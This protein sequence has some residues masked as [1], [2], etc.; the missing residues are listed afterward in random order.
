MAGSE[1]ALV[2]VYVGLVLLVAKLFEDIVRRARLPG[3]IGA[4]IAGYILGPGGLNIIHKEHVEAMGLLLVVGIDFLLF[5]AGAEELSRMRGGLRPRELSVATVLMLSTTA[6]TAVVAHLL[7][8][9]HL[10][11]S[12]SL[13]F[14]IVMAIV[15]LGPLTRALIDSGLIATNAGLTVTR[16]GLIAEVG[17][18]LAFN[19]VYAG[20][21]F[22]NAI[23]TPLFFIAVYLFG[24]RLLTRILYLVEDVISAREAPF[25]IIVA[26][27][28]TASYLAEIIGFNAAVTA[29]LLGF[30]ASTYLE[31]R[32][33][34][35]ERL[36]AFTYGF[37]E[38]LFFAGIGLKV[39]QL[40][41]SSMAAM[42]LITLAAA[43]PKLLTASAAG[44][45]P[46][47]IALL[48]KG[49]VDA[50]LL[51]TLYETPHG[52]GNL[53]P[54]QLYT[55]GVFSMLLLSTL[56]ALGLRSIQPP[57][58]KG[59]KEPWRMRIGELGLGYDV[60]RR[61]DNL[62]TVSMFVS[63]SQG[64]AVV[65]IDE[66]GRPIGYITAAD[67]I[68]IAP[69][70]MRRL[71]AEE[72]MRENVP[73]VKVTDRVT[74]LLREHLVAEPIVA[75]VDEDGHL[76]GTLNPHRVLQKIYGISGKREH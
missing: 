46:T 67:L 23:T 53:I 49:G 43:A 9:E 1:I 30:F 59:E 40:D 16:I 54:D 13:A 52:K 45:M 35:V 15:S 71:T 28:L 38:P 25:A 37:L 50:A 31:E 20:K 39:P 74:E 56:M 18:I 60:V 68:Y 5:L 11:W 61:T 33:A 70:E 63:A 27:V 29:L 26:L 47:G 51:L 6:A 12:T 58:A 4:I 22:P 55:A 7:Y 73:I 3:F 75:V 21:I 66:D 69:S 72:V 32:P 14:G 65:V 24:R 17:G 34:Y 8:R 19:A 41:P 48:A 42:L 64:G 2:A 62:L 10:D 44:L 57:R 36:K 76:V